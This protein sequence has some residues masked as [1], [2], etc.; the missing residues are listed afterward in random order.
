MSMELVS[1]QERAPLAPVATLLKR[2]NS[3]HIGVVVGVVGTRRSHLDRAL[4]GETDLDLLVRGADSQRF[5]DLMQAQ[6]IRPATAAPRHD[7]PWVENW[8]GFDRDHGR[9]FHLHVHHRLVT[10]MKYAK[11][12]VLPIETPIFRRTGAVQGVPVPSPEIDLVVQS[13]RALLQYRLRDGLKDGMTIGTPGLP[14]DA[15]DEIDDLAGTV[16]AELFNRQLEEVGSVIPQRIIRSF[17]ESSHDR[18]SGFRRLH[19]RHQIR[20]ALRPYLHISRATA[21][22]RYFVARMR[23][24]MHGGVRRMTRRGLIV[25][26]VGSDGPG[27]STLVAALEEWL[28][29]RLTVRTFYM[30]TKAPTWP[31]SM[32][33]LVGR[34]VRKF[35][36]QFDEGPRSVEMPLRHTRDVFLALTRVSEA[37]DRKTR[38]RVMSKERSKG[39]IAIWDRFPL[40][41]VTIDGRDMDGA[42]IRSEFPIGGRVLRSLA[43]WEEHLMGSMPNPDL[44]IALQVDADVALSRSPDHNRT[45]I[46]AKVNAIKAFGSIGHGNVV[47]I[48]ANRPFNEVL[49]EAKGVLWSRI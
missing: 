23:R 47:S 8:I 30:G 38:A 26:F 7:L 13:A 19:L 46:E 42:R 1:D 17:P 6:D 4:R 34:V 21:T 10:G 22:G 20:R 43:R 31:T 28:G 48:Y 35:H 36:R 16:S 27:K 15:L 11:E 32:L 40:E 49:A 37:R 29:W 44:V 9:L 45:H 12:Y 2:C 18:A 3:A 25:A 5:R 39:T 33:K 41:G 14:G 24:R